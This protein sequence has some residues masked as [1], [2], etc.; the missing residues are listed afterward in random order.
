[1]RLPQVSS[2]GIAEEV[3]TALSTFV[4]H[5]P[6][7]LGVSSCGLTGKHGGNMGNRML[8]DL[9][10]SKFGDLQRKTTEEHL[11]DT[12]TLN[13]HEDVRPNI[14]RMKIGIKEK[15]CWYTVKNG[16]NIQAPVPRIMDFET[17]NS[18]HSPAD[19]FNG[20]KTS[21]TVV[22][23]RGST[24]QTNRLPI[25]KRLLSPLNGMLHCNQFDSDAVDIGHCIYQS[26]F[27]GENDKCGISSSQE[28]KKAH[29][30]SSSVLNPPVW[31]MSCFPEWS[32]SPEDNNP[33]NPIL[34]TDGPQLENKIVQPH[35]RF[36]FS[37]GFNHSAERTNKRHQTQAMVIPA[38]KAIS[39]PLSPL[40]PNFTEGIKSAGECKE[41]ANELDDVHMTFKDMENSLKVT[42]Q[43][44]K[45]KDFQFSRT[46]MHNFENLKKKID[47]CRPEF[48][49]YIGQNGSQDLNITP[50]NSKQFRS[51]SGVPDRRSLV[52]SFE[53]S[54]LS[55]RLVS[56]KVNQRIDGF[57]AVLNITGG[58]FSPKLQKLPFGVTSV[59]GDNY[60]LYYSSIDLAGN[61]SR[62]KNK[63]PKTKRSLGMDDSHTEKSR[64]QVPMKG[65]IQ[66]VL[67]N[68][69][70]T[71]IHT[72]ICSYDL[73]DMPTGTKTFLRQRITLAS[74][75]ESRIPGR[76]H[77]GFEAM[78]D[79]KESSIQNSSQS[80]P[81][82]SNYSDRNGVDHVKYVETEGSSFV[83]DQANQSSILNSSEHKRTGENNSP[84]NTCPVNQRKF[85]HNSSKINKNSAGAGVLRYALHLRFLCPFP[86]KCLKSLQRCNSDP[87]SIPAQEM[88]IG[89][90]RH[91][92][93]YGDMRVVF[94]QRHSDADEG[95]LRVEYDFPSN[96]KY[97][98]ISS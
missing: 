96:P 51:L 18:M 21:S 43:G 94:P 33:A 97:F 80:S 24:T 5:P 7:L 64:L 15:S 13:M 73:T 42:H 91:F 35:N 68:P 61:A 57:L 28:H 82:S 8:V 39:P 25:R 23:N 67:S 84:S 27:E 85:V 50:K 86:K 62:N 41:T 16:Q 20:K 46:S 75:G 76:G 34:F 48:T 95:K 22:S 30:G 17:R 3:A 93:L 44:Q 89:G 81:L 36:S 4:Q 53:E 78:N 88:D 69:E 54:L 2:S 52:G 60:L 87:L 45:D 26:D 10:Q 92:Y 19:I 1:M 59:D 32:K 9:P 79:V 6:Q 83:L 11:R 65:R 70:K 77:K 12:D 49:S 66:L 98:D 90:E 37:P 31:S 74:C 71:P 40:G 72:F 55:G 29:I 47:I 58:D 56:T 14:H 63:S 38:K